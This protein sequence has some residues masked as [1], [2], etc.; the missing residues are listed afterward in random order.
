L[1]SDPVNI[2]FD[3]NDYERPNQKWRCG[4]EDEGVACP[5]GPDRS[6][7]CGAVCTPQKID[8]RYFCNNASAI[9]GLCDHGPLEDGS[10][11]FSPAQCSPAKKGGEYVCNRGVCEE[12]PRPDG[13]CCQSFARCRPI[14]TVIA[15]R[16]LF[17]ICAFAAALG[18]VCLLVGSPSQK[19]LINPGH[20]SSTH[21]AIADSCE[22]CH[23]VG[24]GHLGDWLDAAVGGQSALAQN[25]QCIACHDDIGASPNAA[26]GCSA[27]T[28]GGITDRIGNDGSPSDGSLI[29]RMSRASFHT[30]DQLAC[31][32]CHH[33]HHGA[34]FDLKA[35]VDNQCQSC[36]AATFD[37]FVDG[38]PEFSDYPYRRRTRIYFDHEAHYGVHFRDV[39]RLPDSAA[40][41]AFVIKD[42]VTQKTCTACHEM[43]L[44]GEQMLVRPFEM[45]C[46]PCHA[47]QIEDDSLPGLALFSLPALD[48]DVFDVRKLKR[49][50]K[51][52]EA[53]GMLPPLM[54]LLFGENESF[55]ESDAVASKLDLS[56]LRGATPGELAMARVYL[57]AVKQELKQIKAGGQDE[58]ERRVAA[59]ISS[60]TSDRRVQQLVSMIR[61]DWIMLALGSFQKLLDGQAAVPSD[62]G[63]VT[64]DDD[65]L[66]AAPAAVEN[67][68]EHIDRGWYIRGRD[69][70]LRYR[71]T[72]HADERLKVLLDV[73]ARGSSSAPEGSPLGDLYRQLSRSTATGRCM[74]CH[75]V[76]ALAD[77]TH[78][79]NWH[80]YRPQRSQRRFT[81]F[82]H[83]P[84]LIMLDD[85]GCMA[86][87][88]LKRP[89]SP[90]SPDANWNVMRSEFFHD[91][92]RTKAANDSFHPN[93]QRVMKSDCTQCHQPQRVRQTCTTCHNYHVNVHD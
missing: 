5:L 46:A 9:N 48:P 10:C 45:S 61:H 36:H 15:R 82:A 49:G 21:S 35:M 31:A 19:T 24:D 64:H 90:A 12:G 16:R 92:W 86:C 1:S 6:G 88:K 40:A 68:S 76:D 27:S 60:E 20:V 67:T 69:L 70:S 50:P 34:E 37:S 71:P 18:I 41:E 78:Q 52:L 72:G 55:A 93:F 83:Q 44:G 58:I 84:H 75:T 4:G 57:N 85:Q 79:V 56:D 54:R 23:D 39:G 73:A 53:T 7:R 74:K 80:P 22:K 91:D 11:C 47:H 63:G 2:Q 81:K 65:D 43:D 77:G 26:H 30:T 33:E 38:H 51:V 14:R 28:L 29:L 13:S 87:H 3:P 59:A 25:K 62:D 66:V 89:D 32:T 17:S 42:K 8:D